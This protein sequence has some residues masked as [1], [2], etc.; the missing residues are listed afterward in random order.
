MTSERLIDRTTNRLSMFFFVD[1]IL[2]SNVRRRLRVRN[3]SETGLGG[4]FGNDMTLLNGQRLTICFYGKMLVD[5]HV[6]WVDGV[7]VGVRFDKRIDLAQLRLRSD[8]T[9]NSH[10]V[11]DRAR[12]A[13][14]IW[15]PG[16]K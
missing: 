16:V 15:R 12:I 10:D 2:A 13:G 8:R 5:G 14:R 3:L 4:D 7:R 9:A 1:C 6:A 11:P